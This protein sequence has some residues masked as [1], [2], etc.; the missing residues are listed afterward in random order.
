MKKIRFFG[1]MAILSVLCLSCFHSRSGLSVIGYRNQQVFIK[2]GLSYRVG[3]L[4]PQ[5]KEFKTGSKSASFHNDSMGATISTDAFCGGAFEDLPLKTLD[6]QLFAGME[7]RVVSKTDEIVLDGRG[8]LRT[9][10]EASIDG[11]RLK[12]DAVTIKKNNCT[13]DFVYM[14]PPENY[15]AGL[16]D[17]ETFFKDFSF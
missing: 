2:K 11:V 17:F 3:Y 6:G 12:F 10:S 16:N 8:A 13:V 7:K 15:S 5:W 1:G 9:V 4:G 14:S